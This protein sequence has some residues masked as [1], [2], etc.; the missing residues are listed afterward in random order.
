MGRIRKLL[1]DRCFD[2]TIASASATIVRARPVEVPV[3]VG[4]DQEDPNQVGTWA[5]RRLRV[6]PRP[7]TGAT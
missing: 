2:P 4:D 5:C 7:G 6:G 1:T 3:V